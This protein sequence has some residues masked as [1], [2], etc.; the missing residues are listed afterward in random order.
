MHFVP[1]CIL[2]VVSPFIAS[3]NPKMIR[4]FREVS[5]DVTWLLMVDR[6]EVFYR[7]AVPQKTRL[8]YNEVPQGMRRLQRE[9]S[10]GRFCVFI[11]SSLPSNHDKPYMKE[12]GTWIA[13]ALQESCG[14]MQYSSVPTNLSIE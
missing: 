3:A 13:N 4:N 10:G 6:A 8:R 5:L 12:V 7:Q 2:L 14:D 9:F 11:L 1:L